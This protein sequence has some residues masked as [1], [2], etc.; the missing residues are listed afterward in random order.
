[1]CWGI[2]FVDENIAVT[3]DPQLQERGFKQRRGLVNGFVFADLAVRGLQSIHVDI[4][5]GAVL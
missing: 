2:T 5:I 4:C 1:M 3:V